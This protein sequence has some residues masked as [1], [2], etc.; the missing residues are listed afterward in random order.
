MQQLFFQKL[1]P[2]AIVPQQA[3]PGAA[4]WDIH[5][6]C[7]AAVPLYPNEAHLFRTGLAL[8]IP[9]G[10]CGVV[11]PRSGLGVKH[12][13][14]LGNSLGLIDSDY[15]GELLVCLFNRNRSG[16][17]VYHVNPGERIAQIVF[18]PYAAVQ[19]VERTELSATARGEGGLGS[20]GQQ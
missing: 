15:R 2:N 17:K 18:M 12:G 9:A 19:W 6:L 16:S 13:I 4:G 20:T 5:A 7:G 1:D 10:L 11:M 8:A 3:T 14:V